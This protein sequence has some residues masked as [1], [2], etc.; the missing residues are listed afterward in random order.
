[1][2][3]KF[4]NLHIKTT[5]QEVV[6]H[7]LQKLSNK[8]GSML[9][10]TK[11]SLSIIDQYI[12]GATK[13]KPSRETEPSVTFYVNHVKQ[14]SSV[15]NDFFEWGT[16]EKIGELVST[17]VSEPVMTIGFFD[18]D[19]FEFT[20]FQDG[21]IKAKKYF[22]EEWVKEEYGLG[23]EFIDLKYLEEVLEVNHSDLSEFIDISN[24]EQ[25]IDQLSKMIQI[26]LWVDSEWI[27]EVDEIEENYSKIELRIM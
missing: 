20:I 12:Y 14:W 16:V 7:A 17:L 13:D 8:A 18:E 6:V 21:Q 3:T 9:T 4:A 15:L 23:S 27:G 22:C 24:P 26:N 11:S 10:N 25:A 2:G 1:M 19:I 5:N